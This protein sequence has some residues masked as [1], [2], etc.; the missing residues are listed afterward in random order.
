MSTL[1]SPPCVHAPVPEFVTAPGLWSTA[2]ELSAHLPP[3]TKVDE[4]LVPMAEQG[5]LLPSVVISALAG[6]AIDAG[7]AG[8]LLIRGV[9]TGD[10][11]PTPAS[12]TSHSGKGLT[13]ELILLAV[14]RALGQPVGY[15]AEHG[16]ALVQN[17]LPVRA[18]AAT[19][20]S[21]SSSVDLEFHT[22][23]AFHPYRP[24]YL[25]LAC[26]RSDRA[27]RTF[28]CSIRELLPYLPADVRRTL[29]A[30][31]FRTRVDESFGGTPEMAPGPLVP[32]LSG[33]PAAPTL[34]FDAELMFGVDV[35][36]TKALA[37]LRAIAL[38]QRLAVV[39]EPGDLLVVDNHACIHGRS[40]FGARYDGT[41]RWLQRSF[42]V[43]DLA[44]SAS[45]RVGRII[46][47][48]FS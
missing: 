34:V 33:D 13:S 36:A 22:E 25:L 26:L 5:E 16:G 44:P 38:E 39:L 42:V 43:D 1:A 29:E 18:T 31:R 7:P 11:P 15:S 2:L 45:D 19:Q 17:L 6:F 32:V 47:T 48:V 37:V 23:T 46:N 3:S 40:S 27:A 28:L 9:P 10:L 24:R 41:D 8:S 14:A 20:T 30:P 12:P 21:T 35:G 4:S